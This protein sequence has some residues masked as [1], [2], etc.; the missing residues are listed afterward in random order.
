LQSVGDRPI[1]WPEC[2]LEEPGIWQFTQPQAWPSKDAEPASTDRGVQLLLQSLVADG[3]PAA[4]WCWL[5]IRDHSIWVWDAEKEP[6]E[7]PGK[8]V[9]LQYIFG[10]SVYRAEGGW[11]SLYRKA[12][13]P[14]TI[15]KK[16]EVPVPE[17]ACT[18]LQPSLIS[19]Y[20]VSSLSSALAHWP[21]G[22]EA[23][24][25]YGFMQPD[26]D[27]FLELYAPKLDTPAHRWASWRW[28]KANRWREKK[29]DRER[30][31]TGYREPF[32]T[33][34]Q[35]LA[36]AQRSDQ[37]ARTNL[38][39][40]QLAERLHEAVSRDRLLRIPAFATFLPEITSPRR[41]FARLAQDALRFLMRVAWYLRETHEHPVRTIEIVAGSRMSGV[42]P[43]AVSDDPITS[44]AAYGA[45]RVPERVD[46]P[47]AIKLLLDRLLP[48]AKPA[49]DAGVQLAVEL[50]PGSLHIIRDWGSV[51]RFCA[52]LALPE[53]K[54]L[55]P[56]LGLNLDVAHWGI[57]N[58]ITPQKVLDEKLVR[59]RIVHA[60]VA[61]HARGH[62]GDVPLLQQHGPDFFR[63]W[64][65]AINQIAQ[66]QRPAG[67]PSFS[68]Y[69]SLEFESCRAPDEMLAISIERLNSL[70]RD[71]PI[72]Y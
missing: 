60:H 38:A 32:A 62:F 46:K 61:D 45:N 30:Y 26:S 10:V 50:E 8:P 14:M 56:V 25:V 40:R 52:F 58:G 67:T 20:C 65:V 43:A 17:G 2:P 48:L 41:K 54:A 5:Q 7:R 36:A 53:Y 31:P 72:N 64:L 34:I 69:V 24:E 59:Q 51:R 35:R 11:V 15:L 13:P 1:G 33:A 19:S 23:C 16:P 68:R 29:R 22:A 6:P 63:R 27:E 55:S 9:A 42:W 47:V 66:E 18:A 71:E 21:V 12:P 49:A 57:L 44:E 3:L 39:A 70:L 4:H 37:R 28:K